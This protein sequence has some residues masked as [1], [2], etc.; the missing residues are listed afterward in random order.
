MSKNHKMVYE[1]IKQLKIAEELYK[2]S[3]LIGYSRPQDEYF[4]FLSE[5]RKFYAEDIQSRLNLVIETENL[6]LE[7]QLQNCV[8]KALQNLHFVKVQKNTAELLEFF[9]ETEKLI[10][11]RYDEIIKSDT[12][13]LLTVQI[14]FESHR[15]ELKAQTE[16]LKSM[17]EIFEPVS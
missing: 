8:N 6:V 12:Y 15:V 13:N 16:E 11:A 9:I 14:L 17:V 2:Y 7:S 1:L 3:N 5:R 10:L 4:C